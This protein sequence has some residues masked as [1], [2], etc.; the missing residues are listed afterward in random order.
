MLRCWQ[1][2]FRRHPRLWG[3]NLGPCLFQPLEGA[4]I[5]WLVTPGSPGSFTEPRLQGPRAALA[6]PAVPSTSPPPVLQPHLPP[7][8]SAQGRRECERERRKKSARLLFPRS[9]PPAFLFYYRI[10]ADTRVWSLWTLKPSYVSS[11]LVIF[12]MSI[13]PK[14]F[15]NWTSN[16]Y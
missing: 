8:S 13:V 14:D 15:P 6:F 7:S 4:R 12:S 1:G 9:S 16:L 11:A 2:W 3:E 10:T 5:P